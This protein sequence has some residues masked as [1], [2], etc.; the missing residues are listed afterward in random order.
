MVDRI[1]CSW[2]EK[3]NSR[4]APIAPYGVYRPKFIAASAQ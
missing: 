3:P 2:G 1:D 4:A